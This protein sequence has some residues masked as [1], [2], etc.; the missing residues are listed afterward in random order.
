VR[1]Q[2]PKP[3]RRKNHALFIYSSENLL[4]LLLNI[5]ERTIKIR[6]LRI[7]LCALINA[8]S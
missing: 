7:F 6:T 3:A 5:G 4:L 2:D 8:V 1:A